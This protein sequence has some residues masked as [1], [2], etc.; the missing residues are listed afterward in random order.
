MKMNA[1]NYL[2]WRVDMEIYVCILTGEEIACF[3]LLEDICMLRKL[4]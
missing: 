3:G 4:C 2:E 1:C